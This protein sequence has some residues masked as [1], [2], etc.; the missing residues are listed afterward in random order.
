M[1]NDEL[2]MFQSLSLEIKIEKSKLRIREWY[3]Y[4]G[5]A[6]VRFF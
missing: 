2:K 1:T 6:S 4:W 5:G 3:D